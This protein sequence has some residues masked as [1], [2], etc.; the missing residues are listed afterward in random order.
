MQYNFNTT[1]SELYIVELRPPFQRC[2]I[3]FV[4]ENI[5]NPR[6]ANLQDVVIVGRNNEMMQYVSGSEN[7]TL[8]LDFYS[9]DVERKDVIKTINWLKSLTYNDGAPGSYRNVR[10]IFGELFKNDVWV[11]DSV[12][13]DM[14]IF[15]AENGW[16]PVMAKVKVSFKLDT[17]RNINLNDVRDR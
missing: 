15:D 8:N 13:P 11:I 1:K 3:Q 12:D 16:L 14:S 6:K 10:V 9:D 4:P 2:M 7:M 17:Q 5:S